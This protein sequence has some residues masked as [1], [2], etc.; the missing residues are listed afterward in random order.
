LEQS[1][2]ISII[3]SFLA[4]LSYFLSPCVLPLVP[5]YISYITG[6]SF[7]DL[8]DL[9]SNRKVQKI[10]IIHSLLF[11]LGFSFVFITLGASA[12]FLGQ[13]LARHLDI[14][15]RIGGII[16]TLFGLFIILQ[17]YLVK[18][19]FLLKEKRW[20]LKN[21]PTGYLGSVLIGISF[22]AGWTACSTPALAAILFYTSMAKTIATGIFLLAIFSL[23]LAIPFFLSALA[24]N[25]FLGFFDKV[26]RHL[27]VI[28]I[29]SG[30]LLII[31]GILVF[32]N[33]L[34]IISA[35]FVHW[36]NWQGI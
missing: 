17:P 25:M 1:E 10:T 30:A 7:E 8:K 29:V 13:L 16:I 11:I 19:P 33:Y 4:G 15:R 35:Y 21:R 28:E 3:I 22:S 12:S 31:F 18:V 34:S 32:T 24:V 5:S 27:R 6:V 9:P 20:I 14:V 2:N 26:K 23:G 36:T